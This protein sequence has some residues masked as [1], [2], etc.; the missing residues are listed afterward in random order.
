MVDIRLKRLEGK[1]KIVIMAVLLGV[2]CF[3]SYHFHTVVKIDVPFT[4]FFYIP[5]IL[6]ALWWKRKG[7]LVAIFLS[8]VL[9]LSHLIFTPDVPVVYDCFRAAAFVTIAFVIA[10]VTGQMTKSEELL[11]RTS[12][13]LEKLFN[14][15]NASIIVWDPGL[16]IT[17]VNHALERLTGYTANEV[18]GQELSMLFPETSRDQSL[19]KIVHTLK[20]KYWES[21]EIPIFSKDRDRRIVLWSLANIY[22]EDGTTVLSTIAQGTDIT[23]RKRAE[24]ERE[25]LEQKA[26][27][28]SRLAA[29][30]EMTSGIAH[31]INNPLTSVIGFAQLVM[32]RNIPDDVRED[33]GVIHSEAQRAAE[34]VKNLLTFARKHAHTRQPTN[35][36]SVVE[37]TL[38]LRAYEHR[39]NNTQVITQLDPNLPE[40]MVDYF[41]MQQVFLNII[42]N[43]ETAMLE[44]HNKGTLIITTQK[45]NNTIKVS[46]T[47]DGTG[48][49]EENLSRIFDPFFTTREEGKGTGLGLSISHGIVA[50]HGGRIYARSK[51]GEGTTFVV[52]LPITAD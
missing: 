12:N 15:A 44:A 43:G 27:L 8:V 2:A 28:A 26:Q 4:H 16:R 1:Y 23:E 22:A 46:F 6:A 3:L 50:E 24:A 20:G 36:N 11:R 45:V 14:Y 17:R 33:I 21:V 7:L 34:V 30:G 39:I 38:K 49:A 5:I 52:E 41:Q 40:I 18:V 29:I 32:G 31:E 48:I 19:I 51:L 25:E 9:I 37:D 13:Y 35:I 47:D 10:M 42:L